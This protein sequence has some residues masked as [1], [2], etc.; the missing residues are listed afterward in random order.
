MD[1]KNNSVI[2]DTVETWILISYEQNMNS[3]KANF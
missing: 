1:E 3:D 2:S